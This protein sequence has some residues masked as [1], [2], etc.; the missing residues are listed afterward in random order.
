MDFNNITVIYMVDLQWSQEEQRLGF[1]LTKDNPGLQGEK[2][3]LKIFPPFLLL[4]QYKSSWHTTFLKKAIDIIK[5]IDTIS[6]FC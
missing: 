6:E 1:F 5:K 3:Y 4:V 2:V